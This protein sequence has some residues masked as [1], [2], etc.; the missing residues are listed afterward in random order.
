MTSHG[1][2]RAY[3][4]HHNDAILYTERGGGIVQQ[5]RDT[6]NNC[7]GEV[8]AV[9]RLLPSEHEHLLHFR[10][11]EVKSTEE[12][13]YEYATDLSRSAADLEAAGD[14]HEAEVRCS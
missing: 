7:L 8:E 9:R 2:V 6:F 5:L 10:G 14:L 13:L 4:Q 12:L 11:I 1:Q 3:L